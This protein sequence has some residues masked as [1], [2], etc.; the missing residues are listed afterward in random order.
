MLCVF[1]LFVSLSPIIQNP[2]VLVV[3]GIISR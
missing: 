3:L 2:I 1:V